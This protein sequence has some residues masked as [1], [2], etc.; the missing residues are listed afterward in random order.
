MHI[1]S[2]ILLITSEPL[3]WSSWVLS[4]ISIIL[5]VLLMVVDSAGHMSAGYLCPPPP[6]PPTHHVHC[7]VFQSS[8]LSDRR[9]SSFRIHR[10]FGLW[11]IS[12]KQRT[13]QMV[14]VF[15]F[16]FNFFNSLCNT[17]CFTDKILYSQT[18]IYIIWFNSALIDIWCLYVFPEIT[19][20]H[21]ALQ[22]LQA[23]K[24]K[25]T[26]I[27]TLI[28]IQLEIYIRNKAA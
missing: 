15:L 2:F 5:S 8:W 9:D 1:S 4:C 20:S 12:V 21:W 13:F 24:N 28:Q 3:H 22:V 26:K 25:S 14:S 17:L 6:P 27:Q 7:R 11:R 19:C 23:N 10:M 18:M 16:Q